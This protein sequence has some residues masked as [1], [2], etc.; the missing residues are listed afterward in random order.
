MA[1]WWNTITLSQYPWERTALDFIRA[2]LASRCNFVLDNA[3]HVIGAIAILVFGF[4][5]AFADAS[6]LLSQPLT[7]LATQPLSLSPVHLPEY[8]LR[9]ALRMLIAMGASLVFTF[10]YA[11]LA[12]KSRRWEMVLIPVLDVLQS[13]PVLGFLTFDRANP[14]SIL[15]MIAQVVC[16]ITRGRSMPM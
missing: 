8:A 7:A 10:T 5:V 4:I 14:Q 2:G 12:A 16:S 13:V 11:T 9:T 6:R 15:S 1:T 3:L